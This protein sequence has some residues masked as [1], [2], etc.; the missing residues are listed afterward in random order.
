[1]CLDYN[2]TMSINKN[3]IPECSMCEHKIS[4]ESLFCCL[5][6]DELESVSDKKRSMFFKKGQIIFSEGNQ[7]HG[8]YCIHR[9]K[10]KVHKLGE[11][12]KDQ[13]V[14]FAKET[15]LI[16]YRAILSGDSYY[17]SATALENTEVCY[18][19]KSTIIELIK[20]NH[21]FS[22]SVINL[23]S[24]DLKNAEEKVTHMAQKHVRERIAEAILLLKESYGFMEDGETIDSTL[25]RK[26]I[27]NIAGTTTETSIRILSEFQKDKIIEL[28]G[29]KIKIADLNRLVKT[30]NI[31]E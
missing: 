25:T 2:L 20:S 23:L 11:E 6:F 29:K 22:L 10:V 18:I 4:G 31:F 12:G 27:A 3:T 9:G 14:R 1:M 16:G 26:E 7:P 24:N 28:D 15:Q 19:P 5:N 30:A 8:L 21:N 13:I 17:A